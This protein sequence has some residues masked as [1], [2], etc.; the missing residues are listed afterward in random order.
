M[1]RLLAVSRKGSG[2]KKPF[3]RMV[4]PPILPRDHSKTY[5]QSIPPGHA[6]LIGTVIWRWS[7]IEIIAEEVI[8]GFLGLGVDI[9]RKLTSRLDFKFKLRLLKELAADKLPR[10]NLVGFNGLLGRVEDLYELRN[11]VAH[12][13]WVTINPDKM[14]AVQSLRQNPPADSSG[15]EVV[16]TECSE[17][18]MQTIIDHLIKAGALLAAF[19]YSGAYKSG[20]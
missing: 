20:V 10:E 15:N 2:V 6:A 19:R 7:Y 18:F 4:K 1:E 5:E 9:G 14:P 12:G 11:L 16:L 17:E 8:W 13:Q 3:T